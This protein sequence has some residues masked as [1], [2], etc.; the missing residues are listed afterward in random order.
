MQLIFLMIYGKN[1]LADARGRVVDSR[2][3]YSNSLSL[4]LLAL[5]HIV[6]QQA[7]P[8]AHTL[9]NLVRIKNKQSIEIGNYFHG[10]K[11]TIRIH[12]ECVPALSPFPIHRKT[13]QAAQRRFKHS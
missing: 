1:I 6:I 12:S 10:C 2:D 11:H 5:A 4:T 7:H 8:L 9:I 3:D 13:P